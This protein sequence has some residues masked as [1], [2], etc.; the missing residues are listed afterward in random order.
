M[1]DSVKPD[2]AAP[3]A[4]DIGAHWAVRKLQVVCGTID[5]LSKRAARRRH[6]RNPVAIAQSGLPVLLVLSVANRP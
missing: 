1:F 3:A 2:D 5:R 6:C 4:L